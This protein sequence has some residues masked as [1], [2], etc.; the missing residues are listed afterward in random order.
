MKIPRRRFLHLAVG[1]A[2]VP[3]MSPTPATVAADL[4]AVRETGQ[5]GIGLRKAVPH[6]RRLKPVAALDAWLAEVSAPSQDRQKSSGLGDWTLSHR[7]TSAHCGGCGKE[8]K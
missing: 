5:I 8:S 4:A 3:A 1:A 6:R 2:V 7:S